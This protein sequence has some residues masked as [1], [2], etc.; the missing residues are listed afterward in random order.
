M[1]MYIYIYSNSLSS[2]WQ[3]LIY[4]FKPLSK[5]PRFTIYVNSLENTG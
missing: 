3:L 4:L 2:Q 5:V 1:Y